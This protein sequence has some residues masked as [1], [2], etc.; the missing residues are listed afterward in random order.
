MART[1][2]Q[3]RTLLTEFLAYDLDNSKGVA[4]TAAE[5][6]EQLNYAARWISERIYQFD[7][8]ITL[9]LTASDGDYSLRASAIV[10][11]KVLRCHQ[12]I[13]NGNALLDASRQRRGMWTYQEVQIGHPNWRA[14]DASTPTK[15]WQIGT[16]LYLHPKPTAAVV[17]A[18]NNYIAGTYLCADLTNGS[19]DSNYYDL[20]E[21]LHEAIAGVA[22]VFAADPTASE[23]EALARLGRFNARYLDSIQSVAKSN[24]RDLELLGST[25]GCS[26]P[27]AIRI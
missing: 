19:D 27:R 17:S 2:T 23:G 8:S 24:K 12:V 14:D 16:T 11:R 4:P 18:G 9:T 13:I 6:T 10:S 26:R 21:E 20:P 7:P 25:P 22:A 3:L 15:P 1:L 5:L